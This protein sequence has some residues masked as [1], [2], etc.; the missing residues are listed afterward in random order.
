[1]TETP[2]RLD[3]PQVIGAACGGFVIEWVVI[4]VTF[5]VAAGMTRG[6][7][8]VLV[9]GFLALPLLCA[10]L[11]ISR[12]TRVFGASLLIGLLLGSIV[13]AGVCTGFLVS[14]G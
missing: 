12:R 14:A 13:G 1:M 7:A 3:W 4:V 8:I 10:V 6:T 9:I 2:R 11:L 5:V